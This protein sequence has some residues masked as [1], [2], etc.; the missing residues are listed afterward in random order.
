QINRASIFFVSDLNLSAVSTKSSSRE[1]EASTAKKANKFIF[2]FTLQNNVLKSSFY[3]LYVVIVQPGNKILQNDIWG[4]DYFTLKS[5]VAKPYTT[6]VHF[7][8]TQGEKKKI[9]YTL[10]PEEFVPGTYVMQ[11]YQ[12]GISIGETS[13]S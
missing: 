6:K 5:G 10:Q 9:L 1:V 12:N 8:Y 13:K 2:S 7:D 4:A 11:V 3:D